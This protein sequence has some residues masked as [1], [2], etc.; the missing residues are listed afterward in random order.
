ML[1]RNICFVDTP[2]YSENASKAEDISR[3]VSYVESLLYQTTSVMT[4]DDNDLVGVVSGNGGISV[5]VVFYLLP[6]S[7][8]GPSYFQDHT[9]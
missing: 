2:G 5:D 4:L 7:E 8:C 9:H 3:V 6:P 1:E